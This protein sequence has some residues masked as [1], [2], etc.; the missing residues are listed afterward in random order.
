VE[1]HTIVAA[2][3]ATDEAADG[4]ALARLLAGLTDTELLIVR[5]LDGLVGHPEVDPATQRHVRDTIG[6]T[7]RAL[8]AA[9]PGAPDAQIVPVL[10]VNIA[11]GLHAAASTH[12]VDLLVVGSS[13]HSRAGRMLIG[14]SAEILVNHAPC[15]VA[16][17][18]PGYRDSSG[19]GPGGI[20]CAYDG[21]D[22]AEDALRTAAD[23]AR[24]AATP[25]RAIAVGRRPEAEAMLEEAAAVVHDQTHGEVDTESLALH[26][27]PASALIAQSDGGVGMLVMGSRGHGPIRRALLGSVS[28]KVV[29]NCRCPVIVTPRRG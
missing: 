26:G 15:P 24:A 25:L 7:R 3:D 4:L 16:V 10:D 21:T 19:I 8:L 28:T 22:A 5:V 12:D 29:R 27:D 18:P 13:H 14:G 17:A 2:Y 20:G 6:G 11:H 9:L 1:R 23:L